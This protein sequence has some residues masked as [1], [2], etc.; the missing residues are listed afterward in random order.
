M[1]TEQLTIRTSEGNCPAYLLL[2]PGTGPWPAVIF[3]GDAGGMRPAM[4]EMARQLA[5]TG[6]IVLLP[7]LYYR[8][9]AYVPLVPREVF[10]GDVMATLG[11]MMATIDTEKAGRDAG[12]FLACLDARH[13]TAGAQVGAVGFCMGGGLAIAVAGTHPERFAAVAS[14]H[15]GNLATDAQ[16]SPHRLLSRVSA[17]I[18]VASAEA[19]ESYP[20]AMAERLVT[21]MAEAGTRYRT[22]EY[23][24]AS[25]GWM[26]PDFP[27]HNPEAAARGWSALGNLFRRTLLTD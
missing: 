1:P 7:D 10:A 15:G 16:D 24:G 26:V 11:P 23:A 27:T 20:P 5:D 14:F 19:D 13:D 4:V 8:Y 18:Y 12:A 2:P 21:A 25:H 9:G 6:F 3:Y 17:E 22:E